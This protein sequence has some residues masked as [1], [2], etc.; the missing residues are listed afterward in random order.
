MARVLAIFCLNVGLCFIHAELF[1]KSLL[2][3]IFHLFSNSMEIL[4]QF[5]CPSKIIFSNFNS[6]T[7]FS[8]V[9]AYS[10]TE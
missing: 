3:E 10:S 1:K 7:K 4:H 9:F 5:E 8:I 6:F 2:I